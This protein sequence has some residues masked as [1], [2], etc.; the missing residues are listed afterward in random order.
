MDGLGEFP[1][2]EKGVNLFRGMRQDADALHLIQFLAGGLPAVFGRE[3]PGIVIG[4]GGVGGNGQQVAPAVGFAAGLFPQLPFGGT[5]G[6]FLRVFPVLLLNGAGRE[7]GAD[8]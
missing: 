1:A 4:D 2:G 6:G 3:E 8:E 5:Q 7:F